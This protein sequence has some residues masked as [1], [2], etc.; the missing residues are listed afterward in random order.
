MPNYQK[1]YTK[2]FNAATDALRALEELNIGYAQ[3]LLRRAQQEAE[4]EYLNDDGT[5]SAPE[6]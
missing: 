5:I 4:E 1:L 2:M 6:T 3:T